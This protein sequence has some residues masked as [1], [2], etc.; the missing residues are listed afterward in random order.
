MNSPLL[1]TEGLVV[2]F[3]QWAAIRRA[4]LKMHAKHSKER[5]RQK[6]AVRVQAHM[7]EVEDCQ[8]AGIRL[9][10]TRLRQMFH[11]IASD[12]MR[13]LDDHSDEVRRLV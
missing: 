10:K 11:D 6:L 5:L 13:H 3:E 1:R 8:R 2:N 4:K 7:G 12:A 9:S